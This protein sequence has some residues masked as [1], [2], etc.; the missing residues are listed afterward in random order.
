MVSDL[1][2]DILAVQLG[3]AAPKGVPEIYKTVQWLLAE[4]PERDTF[5]ATE[6][7]KAM[8]TTRAKNKRALNKAVNG[9]YLEQIGSGRG[10]TYK[11]GAIS[12]TEDGKGSKVLPTV[13]EVELARAKTNRHAENVPINSMESLDKARIGALAQ[14]FSGEGGRLV[15]FHCNYP[16][17]VGFEVMV[18]GYPFHPAHA[19]VGKGSAGHG[20]TDLVEYL[21]RDPVE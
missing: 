3:G 9:E 19:P 17:P 15:C 21:S 18:D 14:G 12:I 20:Q 13:E 10:A 7:A 8:G 2:R 1:L 11:L 4:N 5:T 6:I 16:I